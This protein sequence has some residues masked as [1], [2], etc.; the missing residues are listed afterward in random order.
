MKKILF[1]L[2]LMLSAATI[3]A[4][5]MQAKAV[6]ATIT[7]PQLRC[8]ECKER[9][10][11]HLITEKGPNEDAG[12]VK[13]TVY[14]NSGTLR[15]QYIPDRVTLDYIRVSIAN[16]G[17]DAD[18]VKAEPD[19]YKRLPNVCKKKEDGGGPVKGCTLPPELRVGKV[20]EEI[21]GGNG[22]PY[23]IQN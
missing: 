18:T 4:Q 1:I 19:S 22:V 23:N 17:F 6:W 11:Q 21:S 10:E 20:D 8:W 12:I 14:M 5:V 3:N 13:W 9:L 2:A 16:A 15:I 7:I